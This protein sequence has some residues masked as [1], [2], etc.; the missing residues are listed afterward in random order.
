MADDAAHQE[1][2]ESP[3]APPLASYEHVTGGL[4]RP[5]AG[6]LAGLVAGAAV[7]L[8]MMV[9]SST[10]GQGAWSVP[11]LIAVMWA[12]PDTA[13][14]EVTRATILGVLTYLGASTLMGLAAL[15]FLFGLPPGRT[16]LAAVTYALAAYPA[17]FAFIL[18]WAN[19]MMVERTELV[20]TALA[21]GLFGLVLGW[22]Y[23]VLRR[24]RR[25]W[26][27]IAY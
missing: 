1:R 15:P 16:M 25:R 2:L 26:T 20:P 22:M 9:Y 18:T 23:L 7:A 4:S 8:V 11:N 3:G 5:F 10:S 14:N 12:G 13:G 24:R 21:Y 17:T 6:A 19:P 27:R